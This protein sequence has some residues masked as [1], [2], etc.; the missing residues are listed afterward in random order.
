MVLG[1]VRAHENGPHGRAAC[2]KSLCGTPKTSSVLG[3]VRAHKTGPCGTTLWDLG[4]IVLCDFGPFGNVQ[5]N[6]P[7][8][9]FY[10]FAKIA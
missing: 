1:D 7:D 8:V 10:D 3:D 4:N 9:F 2:L 5:K 6:C